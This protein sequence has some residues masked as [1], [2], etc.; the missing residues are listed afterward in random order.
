VGTW[1]GAG[2]SFVVVIN[3][4][5][6]GVA[7]PHGE[8]IGLWRASGGYLEFRTGR[9]EPLRF[10]WRISDD[11]KALTVTRLRADRSVVGTTTLLRR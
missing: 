9:V 3:A 2:E 11:R 6:S 8:Q 5:G 10:R 7:G 1:E 4:S